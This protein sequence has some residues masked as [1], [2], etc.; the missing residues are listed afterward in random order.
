M[1]AE[2]MYEKYLFCGKPLSNCEIFNKVL[3]NSITIDWWV[4]YFYIKIK[5]DELSQT[6]DIQIMQV[7]SK[8]QDI[9]TYWYLIF[10]FKYF[11]IFN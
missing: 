7:S 8:L 6:I 2:M 5:L 11:H 4:N 10:I 9:D 1:S 3:I